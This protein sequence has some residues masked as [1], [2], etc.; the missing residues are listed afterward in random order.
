MTLI[1]EDGYEYENLDAQARQEPVE[2]DRNRQITRLYN[3]GYRSEEIKA[4]CTGF[5]K[6]RSRSV[7]DR[8]VAAW[9]DLG[10]ARAEFNS[11]GRACQPYPGT[12]APA[13]VHPKN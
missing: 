6:G 5:D 4:W 2:N 1:A 12:S 10:R 9:R 3:A 8:F 13:G 11:A 7:P